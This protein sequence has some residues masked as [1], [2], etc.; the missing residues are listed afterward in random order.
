MCSILVSFVQYVGCVLLAVVI[1]S[2]KSL[3][4]GSGT[5]VINVL[6]LFFISSFLQSLFTVSVYRVHIART[7]L[8]SWYCTG[9]G[10]FTMLL[11]SATNWADATVALNRLIA[12]YFPF[13]Y[14]TWISNVSLFCNIAFTLVISLAFTVLPVFG[15]LGNYPLQASGACGFFPNGNWGVVFFTLTMYLPIV[16]QGVSYIILF[17]KT[18]YITFRRHG[19]VQAFGGT[20][21]RKVNAEKIIRQ[22]TVLAKSFFAA[23]VWYCVLYLF[24]PVF[25]AVYPK[26]YYQT[27]V[28][29]WLRTVT[30]CGS[31]FTPVSNIHRSRTAFYSSNVFMCTHILENQT[32]LFN[33]AYL[34][35]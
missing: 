6:S 16:F 34:L 28:F 30:A 10:F 15:I 22:R 11:N 1:L 23:Y 2:E 26:L 8:P 3:R 35:Y 5:L 20:S 9:F 24:A 4:K 33:A 27:S 21:A 29:L 17:S 19:R 25:G 13:F 7:P 32:R 14:T 31:A 12:I 18:S